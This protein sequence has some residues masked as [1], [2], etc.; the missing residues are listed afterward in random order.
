MLI[1]AFVLLGIALLI[2]TALAVMHMREGVMA[3]HWSGGALHALL[4]I[5][6]LGCLLLALR[7]P[8]R[9]VS[10]GTASFGAI[11][12]ALLVLAAAIGLMLL[13]TRL[14]RR[15]IA[16]ALIGVHATLAV[17]GFVVLAAYVLAG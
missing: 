16:G 15:R 4:A 1:A 2:G 8:A 5:V 9:G 7:G 11:A 10:Q 3:P 6:G 12:A 13:G 14:G 17:G